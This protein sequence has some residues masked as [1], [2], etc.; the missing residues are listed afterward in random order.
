MKVDRLDEDFILR[1]EKPVETWPRKA[2]RLLHHRQGHTFI[3]V[4]GKQPED[5]IERFIRVEGPRT[6]GRPSS[7]GSD[8]QRWVMGMAEVGRLG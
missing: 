6:S 8:G 3:A 4:G 1:A 5:R 2:S 7:L